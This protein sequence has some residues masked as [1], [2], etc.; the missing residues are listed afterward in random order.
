MQTK[1]NNMKKLFIL[2][3]TLF[4]V[5]PM[6]ALA[7]AKNKKSLT[8]K[9]K[10]TIIDIFK[11]L[12]YQYYLEFSTT[13]YYGKKN[14]MPSAL[15]QGVIQN[16]SSGQAAGFFFRTHTEI[17]MWYA[18]QTGAGTTQTEEDVFGKTNALR[19]ESILKKYKE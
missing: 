11:E 13:E 10:Q 17:G 15:T 14:L 18:V 2:S 8:D 3:V 5:L 9:E 7:Q 4:F 19:L 16:K 6:G 12:K 1:H